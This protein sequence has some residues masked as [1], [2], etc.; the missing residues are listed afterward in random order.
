ME[1]VVSLSIKHVPG[2][3]ARALAA[4]A[5][6]NHRSIQGELLHILETAVQ[7]TVFDAG[8]IRRRAEALGLRTDAD[9]VPIIRELRDSR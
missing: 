6:R 9:S 1:P 5:S 2:S 8:R 7:P 4:R 3:I